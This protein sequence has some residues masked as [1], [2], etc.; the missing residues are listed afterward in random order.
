[1]S[2]SSPWVLVACCD[3]VKGR[4]VTHLLRL[5]A[6]ETQLCT[7]EASFL[8]AL[9]THTWHAVVLDAEL[10]DIVTMCNAVHAKAAGAYIVLVAAIHRTDRYRR[11][12][13]QLYGADTVIE[14]ESMGAD[15]ISRL[16]QALGLELRDDLSEQAVQA[17]AA[18]L[19]A[20]VVLARGPALLTCEA[21]DEAV[22]T[23]RDDLARCCQLA[24][25][26]RV[27]LNLTQQDPVDASWITGQFMRHMH[28]L[29]RTGT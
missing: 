6:V 12:P 11:R 9:P 3:A 4:A 28:T 23:V 24:N 15:L 16:N 19:V 20:D 1:M 26:A 7:D 10:G 14:A 5:L 22:Q 18:T 29:C 25:D 17:L 2:V 13:T 27:A 21:L 8:E